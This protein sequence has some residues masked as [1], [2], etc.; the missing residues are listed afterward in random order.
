[1]AKEVALTTT[2]NPFDPITQ[3]DEWEQYDTSH[4]Y[5]TNE[6]LARICHASP[7]LGDEMY[8][9]DL[10]A[11]IDEAVKYNVISFGRE[12]VSYKKVVHEFAE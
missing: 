5:F 12:G 7:E 1:M 9:E 4:R 3:Y 2:D 10:E 8:E 11:S 6:F